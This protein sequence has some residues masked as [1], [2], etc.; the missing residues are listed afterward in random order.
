MKPGT[1]R[2][3]VDPVDHLTASFMPR[4]NLRKRERKALRKSSELLPH[5][6]HDNNYFDLSPSDAA[7]VDE[8]SK[9][10]QIKNDELLDRY[11]KVDYENWQRQEK[12]HDSLLQKNP[13]W[14]EAP[15]YLKKTLRD[16]LRI[17]NLEGYARTWQA[18]D[19]RK[20]T[21]DSA[22]NWLFER[23]SAINTLILDAHITLHHLNVR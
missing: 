1:L 9:D 21:G 4:G 2:K 22:E 23:K 12:I 6:C 11:L 7:N 14:N 17:Q 5:E 18:Q 15:I 20:I 16:D 8:G 13:D 3:A 10:E 19:I